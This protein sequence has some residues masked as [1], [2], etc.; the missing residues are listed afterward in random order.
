M[1]M[2]ISTAAHT[3]PIRAI[4]GGSDP[5]GGESGREIDGTMPL[6]GRP[7]R[8][9]IVSRAKRRPSDQRLESFSE[10][11]PTLLRLETAVAP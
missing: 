5:S 11:A 2:P 9:Q 7:S 8:H 4:V 3:E 1:A 6:P 10:L